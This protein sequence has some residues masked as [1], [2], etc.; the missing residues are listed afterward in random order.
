[1]GEELSA[2]LAYKM[3]DIIPGSFT[4]KVPQSCITTWGVMLFLVLL[5]IFFTRKMEIVPK[6][7]QALLEWFMGM[8]YK[9]FYG[10]LGEKGKRFIPYLLTVILY[11][12]V[13]NMLG[14]CGIQPPTKDMN[15]AAGLALMSIVLVIY[16]GISYRGFGK[17]VKHFAYPSAI[18]TP[19]NVLEIG[20]KPLS[21]CMRLYGNI[22]G[23]YIIMELIIYQ[24]PAVVPLLASAYFDMFD[25]LLQAFVFS[26]LTS[27]YISEAMEDED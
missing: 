1:M 23:A 14:L 16:A 11:L 3:V 20:I 18:I 4:F 25:G 7:R 2:K 12:G 13:S 5:S 15:V 6:G 22:L 19:L 17:W 27:M 24:I 10:I 21:L 26:F 9:V 8:L